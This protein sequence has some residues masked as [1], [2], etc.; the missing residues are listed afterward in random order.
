MA[1]FPRVVVI[2]RGFAAGDAVAAC[3]ELALARVLSY[4]VT[5]EGEPTSKALKAIVDRFGN[6]AYVGAGTVKTLEQLRFA[7]GVGASFIVSPHFDPRLVAAAKAAGVLSVP[8]A[9]TPSEILAAAQAGADLVKVFP[10]VTLGGPEYVRQIRAPIPE[11][12]L[13]VTG[14]VTIELGRSCL[15]A[16]C[17]SVAASV[18]LIDGQACETRDWKKLAASVSTYH[19]ALLAVGP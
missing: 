19:E 10:I 15:L 11:V 2:L 13:L 5:F 17:Q 7:V 9:M 8:G 6:Q 12:P 4:E 14:G 3:E 1:A 16:G 18:A